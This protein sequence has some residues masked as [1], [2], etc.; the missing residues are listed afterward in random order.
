MTA[1]VLA[2]TIM[3][4]LLVGIGCA[5]FTTTDPLW[6]HL[7]FSRLGEF[8]D[9]SGFFFN[10]TLITGG[11]L[12]IVFGRRVHADLR[13][14]GAH[15]ARRGAASV[16][17]TLITFVGISLGSVGMIPLNVN[18]FLHDKAASGIVLSFAALLIASTCLLRKSI[19]RLGLANAAAFVLIVIAATFFVSG[20]INLALFEALGFSTIF[21]WVGV[22]TRCLGASIRV[23]QGGEA[24]VAATAES[25]R[26]HVAPARRPRSLSSTRR[27]VASST[28]RVSLTRPTSRRI[29]TRTRATSASARRMFRDSLQHRS[30]YP[31]P[32]QTS[33]VDLIRARRNL[34]P[35]RTQR[36]G[37]APRSATTRVDRAQGQLIRQ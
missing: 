12:I 2:T 10:G 15:R 14:L 33:T 3:V 11:A 22:F 34:A 30:G 27:R 9:S 17:S 7:H 4:V 24:V 37:A 29:V 18:Q 28:R 31:R 13:I 6:W 20:A 25:T 8:R 36:V 1:G 21:G 23:K 5:V 35:S 16:N 32:E 26:A 19:K